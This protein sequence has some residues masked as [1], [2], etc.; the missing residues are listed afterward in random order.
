MD[1]IQRSSVTDCSSFTPMNAA[2]SEFVP[3]VEYTL[4]DKKEDVY[5]TFKFFY[6]SQRKSEY[7]MS[8]D[9]IHTSSPSAFS[10]LGP[11]SS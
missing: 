3:V 10:P 11:D 7:T 5:A 6:R 8:S 4:Y 1:L 2:R 9:K